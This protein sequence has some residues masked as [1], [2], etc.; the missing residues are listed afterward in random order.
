MVKSIQA[1][2]LIDNQYHVDKSE[3]RAKIICSRIDKLRPKLL[4]MTRRNPLISTKFSDR[5]NSLIRVVDEVPELLLEAISSGEMRIIPLPDLGT[6]PKDENTR[7]FQSALAEARLNDEIY[8]SRLDEINQE[9]DDAPNLL[10]KAERKLKDRLREK[11]GMPTRQTKGN[12]SL[13]QHAKNHGISPHYELPVEDEQHEDGRHTDKDIQTLMLPDVMERRLNALHS[14]ERTWKEETGISVLHAAFGFLEWEDGN[15]STTQFSPLILT[16]VQLEK[17]RTRSGQEFWVTSNDA[18]LEENKILAEKLRLEFNITLPEYTGQSIESYLKEVIEQ[19]PKSITWKVRR[20][21]AIGVFPSARLAMYHDLDPNG[22]DFSTHPLISDLFGGSETGYDVV[23]FGDEYNIDEPEIEKKVPYLIA[24]ADSSQFSTIVDVADGKN[25]AVEGPPGTGKSQTIVNTIAA[26]L[27]AGKKV[28]FVAEKSAALEVVKARLEAFGI[29]DFVL[30]LQA[31]RSTKEQVIT[32]IRN[33][34]EMRPCGDPDEL[35]Q[36]IKNFKKTR[37]EL[38]RYVDTLSTV[39]EDTDFT[40]H[41]ILGRSIRSS[42][43]VDALPEDIRK[44]IIPEVTKLSSNKLEDIVFRC[45]QVEEAWNTASN[46][47]D[48][49]QVI[50]LPN[51]DPFK[52]NKILQLASETS[53]LYSKAVELRSSLTDFNL[54]VDIQPD[55]LQNII[56]IIN[57][58]TDD[59]SDDD[60]KVVENLATPELVEDIKSYLKQVD[61]WQADKEHVLKHLLLPLDNKTLESLIL[62]KNICQKHSFESLKENDLQDV[63][64]KNKENL[65]NI[66]EVVLLFEQAEKISDVLSNLSASVLIKILDTLSPLSKQ[67][68]ALRSKDLDD[69][70]IQSILIK[71]ITKTRFLKEQRDILD[72]KFSLTALPEFEIIENQARVLAQ[73]GAFAFF[74]KEYRSAKNFYK[75]INKENTF[76]KDSAAEELR[77]MSEW[78]SGVK[79]LSENEAV[80]SILGIHYDGLDTDFSPFE[81]VIQLFKDA[82]DSFA[83]LD[84]SELR[85]FIKYGEADQIQLLP[86]ISEKHP[87]HAYSD[88]T[89]DEASKKANTI[90]NQL[91]ECEDDIA[92]LQNN[93]VVFKDYKDISNELIQELPERLEQLLKEQQNLQNNNDVK[94][95][96]GS[97]FKAEETKENELTDSLKLA[98]NLIKLDKKE[99]E[100]FIYSV[101]NSLL[102]SLKQLIEEVS[103]QDAKA[104]SS[105]KQVADLTNTDPAVWVSKKT[106]EEI[107]K[108]MKLASKDKAGLFAYSRLVTTKNNLIEYGYNGFAELM[109]ANQKYSL[110]E[111]IDALIM[112]EMARVAYNIYGEVLANYNG[113]NLALYRKR[114]QELDRKVIRLSRERL[115]SQLFKNARPPAG[116]GS[117]KKSTYTQLALLKNE[118]S[119]KQRHIAVRSLTQRAAKALLELKPCWMMSPLAVAQYLPK[120]GIEFD[121]LIVDEASQM[122][123]EDAV[124]A[125]IR[126]KQAMVVGDPNQ[127]PPTGFFRK[128]FEDEEA[129][130]DEKVTE[131]SILEMANACFKPAR[132]L[133]WHYRSRN[134]GLI[135]FSNRHVYG[136]NLVVFPSAQEDHPTMGVSYVKVDGLYST[137]TNPEEA[138]AMVDAIVDFMK[139]HPDK[140]L[141]VVLLNQKQRDLLTEEMNYALENNSDARKYKE[142]WEEQNEGLESFFIKNLE[143]VQ[144]DERDVIFIGTVYGPEKEGAPVMQRFGPINGVAGRRRLNVLFSRAKE[145]IVTFSSMTASDIRAEEDGNPGVYM[146]G[147]WLEYAASGVL[148]S[149]EHSENEPDSELEEHVIQQIKSIGCEAIPQVGV[150]GFSIDI[151]VKHSDWPHGFIMGVECD[152]ATYHSSVSARDRDRLRQE[153][154]E[155]LGWNLYRIWSTD[156]FEDPIR[157]TEKLRKAVEK[158]LSDLKNNV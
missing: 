64:E 109:F 20:W 27:A 79:E 4:D 32:S 7:E 126:T 91:A 74:S 16:P 65:E 144:G 12:L 28:L 17:R 45:K 77:K 103:H 142:K 140:S 115:Q 134:S 116:N 36:S 80:K 13:Q 141:G 87:I 88:L 66:K 82:D 153:V 14:K 158:R 30:P 128:V 107:S 139:K 122:T 148:H 53:D 96:L 157:E 114:L 124:G 102:G 110:C 84:Y 129:D 111:S 15:N 155:G 62:I 85:T 120:G 76:K 93:L 21:A 18:E 35:D 108:F 25:L 31:N 100:S 10:A 121:L 56:D 95:I 52:A 46:Y 99:R 117:G 119:K 97:I 105:I 136:D 118:I 67:V 94:N 63:S 50:Q 135:S 29:G 26:S 1:N 39:F 59:L 6:N 154:L 150:K 131:E 130:E 44:F 137:G 9:S 43:I 11:L 127:L 149:G 23:P 57:Q 104:Y 54:N 42:G 5:S 2:E 75:S 48:S 58:T 152:G 24:D 72:K 113:N 146:L 101:R 78:V 138:K 19:K 68:L 61:A 49:W 132:R 8:L 73:A 22:W 147:R 81:E 151:G 71:Q 90:D 69:P 83:G 98:L 51:I 37:D 125:L 41:T 106:P 92:Q 86:R 40:I 33:R 145:R 133:R 34:I 55:D 70:S 156:W 3:E 60:I 112:R 123:P 89:L 47:S 38:K 143:N